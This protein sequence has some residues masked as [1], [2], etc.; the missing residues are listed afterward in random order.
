MQGKKEQAMGIS[1]R[2]V[3]QIGRVCGRK[4]LK[5]PKAMWDME[6]GHRGPW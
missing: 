1:E 3:I 2:T 4:E 5:T 6:Q